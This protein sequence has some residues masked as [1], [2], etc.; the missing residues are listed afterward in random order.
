MLRD[1]HK[2][3]LF[4]AYTRLRAELYCCAS[5]QRTNLSHFSMI[6]C[7]PKIQWCQAIITLT[8]IA[9]EILRLF[10]LKQLPSCSLFLG[11]LILLK[12]HMENTVGLGLHHNYS[13]LLFFF[14]DAGIDDMVIKN[15]GCINQ[16]SYGKT[17]HVGFDIIF[18]KCPRKDGGW[19]GEG[20]K[21]KKM[22]TNNF[23]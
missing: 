10:L 1:S 8:I 2:D 18:K 23:T 22:H 21:K 12:D 19:D 5:W 15:H 6:V 17:E 3:S 13:S 20:R 14:V 11:K 9:F 4:S 16:T 7:H